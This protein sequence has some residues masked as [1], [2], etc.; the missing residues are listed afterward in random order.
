M[1]CM[2]VHI[3]SDTS[4]NDKVCCYMHVNVMLS[5]S[6]QMHPQHDN[7]NDNNNTTSFPAHDELGT[8][9]ASLV[10]PMQSVLSI[11]VRF[12]YAMQLA[13]TP[14]NIIETRPRAAWGAGTLDLTKHKP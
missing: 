1:W 11:L 3:A 9:E 2:D 13:I 4:M 6:Q 7:N 5:S 8:C 10:F 14:C 12:S